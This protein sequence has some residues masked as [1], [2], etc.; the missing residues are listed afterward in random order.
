MAVLV[1]SAPVKSFWLVDAR[2]F[3]GEARDPRRKQYSNH[4]AVAVP[5]V[6]SFSCFFYFTVQCCEQNI[7]PL[8][9]NM[10]I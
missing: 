1:A 8:V 7:L 2:Q 6:S 5:V 10:W 4:I 3:I 9:Y